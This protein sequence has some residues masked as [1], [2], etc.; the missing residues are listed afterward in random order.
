VSLIRD[1]AYGFH[2]FRPGQSFESFPSGHAA[3]AA[4]VLS[5]SWILYPK[6]RVP[7]AIGVVSADVGIVAVNVHFLSD[8]VAGSF[9]GISTRLFTIVMWRAGSRQ[10]RT[11]ATHRAA[12]NPVAIG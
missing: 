8:V 9:V 11:F 7:W 6:L 2:F 10:N 5:V 12:P 3:V 1:D 4:A